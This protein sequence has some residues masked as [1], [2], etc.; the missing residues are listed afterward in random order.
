M[1]TDLRLLLVTLSLVPAC[2]VGAADARAADPAS[3]ARVPFPFQ[4]SIRAEE[5]SAE[6]TFKGQRLMLYVFG[7]NQFKPYVRELFTLEGDNV[8][9]DAPPDH[10]HHHGLMYAIRVNGVNFW[11]ETGEPGYQIP[12]GLPEMGFGVSPTGVPWISFTQVV[13]WVTATN[14]AA[15]DT[16]AAALLVERRA[17]IVTVNE[18]QREVAL[19]WKAQ[20]EVGRGAERVVLAGANYHGLG[21]RLPPPFN[22]VARHWNSENAAYASGGSGDVTPAK[23]SAV[24]HKLNDRDVTVTLFAEPS[25]DRGIARFFTMTQPFTYLSVTQG[26]DQKTMEYSRGDKW[27]LDYLLTVHSRG[28]TPAIMEKRY[29]EWTAQ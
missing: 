26:L 22:R 10:L 24:S 9:L 1:I 16:A 6:V 15:A 2:F 8:L 23:W 20:F 29:Q 17:L 13:H 21:L 3:V 25:P 7:T 5:R 28:V 18:A 4:Y 19:E 11:E 12:K 14:R 27:E